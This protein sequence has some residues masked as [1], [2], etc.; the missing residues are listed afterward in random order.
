MGQKYWFKMQVGSLKFRKSKRHSTKTTLT[1]KRF[2]SVYLWRYNVHAESPAGDKPMQINRV[3]ELKASEGTIHTVIYGNGTPGAQLHRAACECHPQNG[4]RNKCLWK[5]VIHQNFHV[6]VTEN[7]CNTLFLLR[8]LQ[9]RISLTY[10][11][12]WIIHF[13]LQQKKQSQ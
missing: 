2:C 1:R 13:F 8:V 9:F 3:P 4:P 12:I 7:N 5:R 10:A 11:P 6:A